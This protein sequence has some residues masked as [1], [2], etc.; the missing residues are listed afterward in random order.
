MTG[1]FILTMMLICMFITQSQQVDPRRGSVV[2]SCHVDGILEFIRRVSMDP[3]RT[4]T[5]LKHTIALLGDLGILF[6]R[7]FGVI[8]RQPFVA[9]LLEE[10]SQYDDMA[11]IVDC[12]RKVVNKMSS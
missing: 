12:T 7:E 9:Q 11:T 5:I 2:V 1:I 6:G 3:H 8:L 4:S 10:A